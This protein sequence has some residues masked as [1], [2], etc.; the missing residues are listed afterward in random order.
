MTRKTKIKRI[1]LAVTIL[2]I[3]EFIYIL[4]FCYQIYSINKLI[5]QYEQEIRYVTTATVINVNEY[6]EGYKNQRKC[7]DIIYQYEVK[8]NVYTNTFYRRDSAKKPV[9]PLKSNITRI[10][11]MNPK[12][13]DIRIYK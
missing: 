11:Q 2:I 4:Y 9:I 6:R 5:N 7:Y 1:R 13:T 12:N 3:I 8:N 10:T